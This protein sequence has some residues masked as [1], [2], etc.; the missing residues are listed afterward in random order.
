MFFFKNGGVREDSCC[1]LIIG[2]CRPPKPRA[3]NRYSKNDLD[4]GASKD[5]EVSLHRY[6]QS[7]DI[8]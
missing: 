2:V 4:C 1:G 8:R 5:F 6:A 3:P 7:E